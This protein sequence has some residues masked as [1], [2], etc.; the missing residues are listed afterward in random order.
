MPLVLVQMTSPFI[1]HSM[2]QP[3]SEAQ[4]VNIDPQMVV[5]KG[6]CIHLLALIA[7]SNEPLVQL[8]LVTLSEYVDLSWLDD[9]P[10]SMNGLQL[11]RHES[12]GGF[13]EHGSIHDV[14]LDNI[15]S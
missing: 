7:E 10:V 1:V 12:F 6:W 9:F 5:F 11:A 3:V 13:H 14:Y 15:D 8:S 4:E 2:D